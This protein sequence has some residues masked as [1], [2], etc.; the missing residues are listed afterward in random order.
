MF[1]RT[2]KRSTIRWPT[3]AFSEEF[4]GEEAINVTAADAGA[5]RVEVNGQDLGSLGDSGVGATRIFTPEF[6]RQ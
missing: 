4:E 2:G 6:E 5:V 3:Q 1:W